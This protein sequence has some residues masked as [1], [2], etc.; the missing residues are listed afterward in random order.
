MNK[1]NLPKISEAEIGPLLDKIY[2]QVLNGIPGTGSA[3]SLAND[4]L[5][6]H[7]KV[8]TA[9]KF[10][11]SNQ[12]K[13]CSVSGFVCNL[14]SI[15]LLPVS[16]PANITSV[17][18]IQMRMIAALAYMGGYDVHSDQVQTLVYMTLV[19]TS[20]TDM[21]KS[22]GVQVTNKTTTALLKK[23]PGS[24]LAKIN[25]KIGFRL[26][27]KFGEKGII[28]LAKLLPIAGGIVGGSVDGIE[29]KL[30]ANVAYK[31]FILNVIE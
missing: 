27:T 2:G 24:L 18:Y 6:K 1:L 4:Y 9:A 11:I 5:S 10:L 7:K 14:G 8:E 20:M 25:Q 15:E 12:I 29:T 19:G 31:A 30:V 23:L 17:W 28:T 26:I 3:E 13:K 22:V 16:L 21:C